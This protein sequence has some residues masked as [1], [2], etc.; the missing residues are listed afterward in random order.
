MP[1]GPSYSNP[2]FFYLLNL[3]LQSVIEEAIMGRSHKIKGIQGFILFKLLSCLVLLFLQYLCAMAAFI[4]VT[5]VFKD[6][7]PPPTHKVI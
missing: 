4:D 1:L 3:I 2:L 6:G 5:L 7:I